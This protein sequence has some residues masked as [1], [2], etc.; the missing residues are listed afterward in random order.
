[1]KTALYERHLYKDLEIP[2]LFHKEIMPA[3]K[4]FADRLHWHENLE[5]SRPTIGKGLVRCSANSITM[6]PDE[7][8]AINSDE[9]H[10]FNHPPATHSEYCCLIVDAQF[11][12]ENGIPVDSINFKLH[13]NDK[14]ATELYDIAYD[15]CTNESPFKNLEARTAVLNFLLY[16]C[17]NHLADEG[18]LPAS[19][20]AEPIK[21]AI[22]YIKH[23]YAKPI[24]LDEISSI[25]G[26][27]SYYFTREFK[28]L[29]GTTFVSFLNTFRC[30]KAAAML[31]GGATVTEACF[32][33]GFND[34]GYFSR[35]FLKIMGTSPSAYKSNES[36]KVI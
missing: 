24:S 13:I 2:F 18:S 33:C 27:S 6:S 4:N 20:Y 25:S 29:T 23:N 36:H 21:K 11:C 31:G 35:T 15:A 19:T 32:G 14:K 12:K 7:I 10:S 8:V 9:I 26:F 16:M 1:M 34:I 3:D 22:K 30:E 17:R 5:F 28:K